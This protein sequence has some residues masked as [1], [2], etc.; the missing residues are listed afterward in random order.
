MT[1]PTTG[2]AKA[3]YEAHNRAWKD[4]CGFNGAPWVKQSPNNQLAWVA[5]AQRVQQITR[6]ETMQA[7]KAAGRVRK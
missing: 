3:A 1:T 5:A 7:I 2:L 4:T 6:R